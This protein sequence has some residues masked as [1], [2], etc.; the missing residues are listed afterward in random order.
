MSK[1]KCSLCDWEGNKL[2]SHLKRTH[3]LTR[4][5][6]YDKFL[7]KE[8]EGH[9]LSC[10]KETSFSERWQRGYHMFCDL[11]LPESK[12]L[13]MVTED[14]NKKKSESTKRAYA[15]GVKKVVKEWVES[16]RRNVAKDNER[17]KS[18]YEYAK[19]K[20]QQNW[21]TNDP[22]LQRKL[23]SLSKDKMGTFPTKLEVKVQKLLDKLCPTIFEYTGDFGFCIDG[24]WPDFTSK[25]YKLVIE[26]F[27]SYWH[28]S[29]DELKKMTHYKNSGYRCLIL[30]DYEVYRKNLAEQ[31]IKDFVFSCISR[32]DTK[33]TVPCIGNDDKQ[34]G[35]IAGSLNLEEG[36]VISKQATKGNS[37][38]E[39]S[40]TRGV[41]PNNNLLHE[42][43][44][45]IK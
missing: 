15:T 2:T 1:K 25:E 28:K 33:S 18:D 20:T 31:K 35:L 6:Y 17:R 11:C 4:K 23:Y 34:M 30:W 19:S 10:G 9:C 40:T 39:A 43:P 3:N 45:T 29:E 37:L 12:V 44:T 7:K 13:H 8:N 21:F 27:G 24:L 36:M 22:E 42:C 26:A 38:V 32:D 16:G 41:S 5:E 14:A